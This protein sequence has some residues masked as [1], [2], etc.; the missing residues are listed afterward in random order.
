MN[1]RVLKDTLQPFLYGFYFLR[2]FHMIAAMHTKWPSKCIL[3]GKTDLDA[4]Y[5][6]VH[7]NAQIAATCIAIVKKLAFP[8]L[9]LTF[10]TTPTT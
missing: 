10:D 5:L 3:I 4:A 9:R 6:H 8:C 7:T 1:N 2:I